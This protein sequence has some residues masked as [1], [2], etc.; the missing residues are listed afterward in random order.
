MYG[1]VRSRKARI[2]RKGFS[3]IELIVVVGIMAVMAVGILV[4]VSDSGTSDKAKDATT[5]QNFNAI[6]NA[7]A[8]ARAVDGATVTLNV[9]GGLIHDG[10]F[11]SA[12]N[13]DVEKYLSQP[14]SA[15]PTTYTVDTTGVLSDSAAGASTKTLKLK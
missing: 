7:M 5:L 2:A 14:L 15:F 1:M 13:A 4:V 6:A 12:G 11:L 8:Y 10:S 3:L 9:A